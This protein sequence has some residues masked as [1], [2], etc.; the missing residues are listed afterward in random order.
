MSEHI[1]QLDSGL[2]VAVDP[3]AST[4]SASIGVWVGVGAR[5]EPAELAGVSHFLEHLLFKG[6][7]TRSAL[8]ISQAIDRVGGDINALTSK[9]YT[10]YYC[11]VPAREA[12]M[13]IEVLGDVLTAPTLADADIENERQVILEEL[14]MDDDNPEDVAHRAFARQAFGDHPLGRDVGGT[15]STVAALAPEHIRKFFRQHYRTENTVVAVAGAVDPDEVVAQVATM[16]AAMPTGNG[17]VQRGGSFAPHGDLTLAESSEQ[18][19]LLVGGPA[20]RRSDPDRAALDTVNH[21]F[22]GG[23]SSRL[24]DEIRE[25]RGLAYTVFSSA[26]AYA[27]AGV[28]SVYAGTMP[29]HAAEVRGLIGREVERLVARGV[30]DDELEIARGYLIGAFEMGLED[31]VARMSRIGAQLALD[32]TLTSVDAQIERWRSVGQ[33]DVERVVERVYGAIPPLTVAVGPGGLDGDS[34]RSSL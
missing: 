30:S 1:T 29:D 31:S 15:A 11:R 20:L 19:H 5:D 14:A 25:R 18:V 27:D 34:L 12:A 21:V 13:G 16:F 23:L 6:T 3:M 8:Q 2:T 17:A 32:G 28:W 22:G 4:R 26:V 10:T 9:E 7:T 24:F 33:D